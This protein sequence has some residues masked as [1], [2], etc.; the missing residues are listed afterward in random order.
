MKNIK[1]IFV[2][3]MMIV[4]V[5]L[6]ACQ[7]PTSIENSTGSVVLDRVLSKKKIVIGTTADYP[8]FE[9]HFVKDGQDSVVGIDIDIANEIGKALGVEVEIREMEFNFLIAA[10]KSGKVDIVLAGITPTQERA[11]E[12]A[13]SKIYYDTKM[14]AVVRKED[15]SKFKTLEDFDGTQVGAQKGTS[16]EGIVKDTLTGASLTSQP[17]NPTLILALQQGKL[18]AVI[19]DNIA[20]DEFVKVNPDITTAPVEIPSEDLGTAAVVQKGNEA[21][22]EKIQ[23]VLDQLEAS[24]K[25]KESII[26]NTNL[27]SE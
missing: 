19:M 18:D 2:S 25:L 17:K 6:F 12:V 13:F 23:A 3:M 14:V 24:G 22:L 9:W 20:A 27:M 26:K 4:S 21:F 10:M 7:K 1:I 11:K 8:P 5:F 16:Q 15:A